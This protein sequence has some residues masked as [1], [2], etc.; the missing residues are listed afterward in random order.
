M[1]KRMQPLYSPLTGNGPGFP[2]IR[3]TNCLRLGKPHGRCFS[4]ESLPTPNDG[5]LNGSADLLYCTLVYAAAAARYQQ[6]NGLA[7][8]HRDVVSY[9]ARRTFRMVF[10]RR[11]QHP[12]DRAGFLLRKSST[13]AVFGIW[14]SGWPLVFLIG[15]GRRTP[16]RV[17]T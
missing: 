1:I 5:S 11:V 10:Q 2:L 13:A 16:C 14:R 15:H 6:L 9:L 7:G 3:R 17:R 4:G 12:I 8:V